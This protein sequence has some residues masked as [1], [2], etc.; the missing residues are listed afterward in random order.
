MFVV[1]TR[2]KKVISAAFLMIDTAYGSP[3]RA[4]DRVHK[5]AGVAAGFCLV[6]SHRT[7]LRMI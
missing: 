7:Y 3:F 5:K 6:T 1:A 2:S 4:D